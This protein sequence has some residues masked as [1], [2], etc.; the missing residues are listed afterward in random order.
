MDAVTVA[1]IAFDVINTPVSPTP[2]TS[3]LGLGAQACK[4]AV[5]KGVCCGVKAGA[6]Q[7]LKL[8]QSFKYEKHHLLPKSSALKAKFKKIGLDPDDFVVCLEQ[9]K[10]RFKP[11]GL[12]TGSDNWNKLWQKFFDDVPNPTKDQV[13]QQLTKMLSDAGVKVMGL[14]K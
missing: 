8:V 1:S 4:P 2:D 13:S 11:G 10:H 9:G 7:M 12:H 6:K 3:L 5:K 14:C